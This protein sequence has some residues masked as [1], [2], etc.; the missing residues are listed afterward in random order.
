[1]LPAAE[2]LHYHVMQAHAVRDPVVR[3][4][5]AWVLAQV[6]WLD[7]P[8]D[9]AFLPALSVADLQAFHPCSHSKGAIYNLG[10]FKRQTNCLGIERNDR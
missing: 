5:Q 10:S 4:F 3:L 7:F 6:L 8:S 9:L 1:M 2:R